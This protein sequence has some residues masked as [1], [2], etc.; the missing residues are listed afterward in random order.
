MS[1]ESPRY[2]R[3]Q[4]AA[5][6]GKLVRAHRK[7]RGL[8]LKDISQLAALGIRFLSEFERGKETAEVGK[9]L[10]TLDA[11]GLDVYVKR[12]SVYELAVAEQVADYRLD[13]IPALHLPSSPGG[14]SRQALLNIIRHYGIRRLSLFGSAARNELERHSDIDLLVE[15]ET[16][17]SPALSGI[18]KIREA[19]SDLFDGRAVDVATAA[20]LNNPYRRRQI[21]RDRVE[22]YAA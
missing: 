8:A 19:F 1:E 2:G 16:G 7:D 9:V 10:K 20:I 5:A 4:D 6:L 3:V 22:I 14:V 21:E 17:H 12:R 13:D 18:M 15:F 11:L